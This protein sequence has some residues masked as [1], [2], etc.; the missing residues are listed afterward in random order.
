[1][2]IR[3]S[4]WWQTCAAAMRSALAEGVSSPSSSRWCSK[5]NG[6]DSCDPHWISIVSYVQC[7]IVGRASFPLSLCPKKLMSQERW[8]QKVIHPVPSWRVF[9]LIFNV[10][11]ELSSKLFSLACRTFSCSGYP[12]EYPHG[13]HI[14]THNSCQATEC[15]SNK[16]IWVG[17]LHQCTAI[18]EK[19]HDNVH[20]SWPKD[21]I[22][23]LNQIKS[24]L[25]LY[26]IQHNI[27]VYI[28]TI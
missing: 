10:C 4:L 8:H 9:P 19:G 6:C 21:N 12:T 26:N 27:H 2:Q 24:N 22:L 1:M 25:F 16:C 23:E 11:Q 5:H 13:F 3:A 7:T 15:R 17:P 20:C 18:S 28:I 14:S